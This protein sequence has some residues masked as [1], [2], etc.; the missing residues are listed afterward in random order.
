MTN[1]IKTFEFLPGHSLRIIERD[2]EPWFVAR[3]VCRAIQHSN[4]SV[5]VQTLDADEEAKFNL[6][7]TG[8]QV[9]IVSESGLYAL[10]L[11]SRKPEA[12]T[13]RKWVTSVVLPA[14]RKDGAYVQGE[15]KVATGEMSEDALVLKAMEALQRKVARLTPQARG[16]DPAAEQTMTTREWLAARGLRGLPRG[17]KVRLGQVAGSLSLAAGRERLT[18][19]QPTGLAIGPAYTEAR[20]FA[21]ETLD[22]AAESIGLR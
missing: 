12:K 16:L 17:V 3:D 18:R 7:P 15:E 13:F 5:A 8:P 14:I 1:A 11:R 6:G 2:G 4:V 22:R 21:R 20:V 19:T 10:V 9:N